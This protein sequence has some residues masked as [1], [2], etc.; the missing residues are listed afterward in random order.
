MD[1]AAVPCFVPEE[2]IVEKAV[3]HTD[4]AQRILTRFADV[5]IARVEDAQQIWL[6]AQHARFR[7][8]WQGKVLLARQRGPF[9]RL[10][11]GTKKHICCLYQNLD[12]A[13][14]CDLN[15]TYCILQ[16][17]LQSSL[18]TWYCN[19]EDLYQE[20]DRE[21]TSHPE[22]FYRIG[23]GELSDSLTFDPCTHLAV[24]LVRFFRTRRNAILELKSKNTHVDELL[25][26]DH[27]GR[28]VV[29]WSLNAAPIARSEEA[30]APDIEA[31]LRA[32]RK[33]QEAGY[34]LGFH[35]D[36]MIDYP[37]WRQGYR[38]TVDRL[39]SAIRPEQIAWISLGA[40]RYP[41]AMD[42]AIRK[43]YPESTIVLGELLPGIDGKY[44]YLK[45]MRLEMFREMVRWI[46]GYSAAPVVY[47]C[48]ESDEVWHKA[49][50]WSPGSSARLK[51]LLDDRVRS[52]PK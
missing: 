30:A 3:E 34:W 24:D 22:H 46:R 20:V 49:F 52:A 17:Y 35:F 42:E 50:G 33:V 8:E 27:G 51:V 36:P 28:T 40:L 29:S 31:R 11:P 15:C 45:T 12:V 19:L 25:E 47:L 10:C 21:L 39:F 41:A 9:L 48:M 37:D 23:T 18:V 38:E 5:P 13:A 1:S 43:N 14:G 2:L 4:L 44:R 16:G 26:V 7:H 6:Q 32:A